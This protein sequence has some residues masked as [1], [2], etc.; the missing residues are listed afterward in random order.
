MKNITLIIFQMERCTYFLR[1]PV[2]VIKNGGGCGIHL[3]SCILSMKG[4]IKYLN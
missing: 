4:Y 3:T 2:K 1:S